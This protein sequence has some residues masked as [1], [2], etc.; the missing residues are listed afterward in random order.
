MIYKG[1]S[2]YKNID[3]S[4]L[5]EI[6][7]SSWVDISDQ[8]EAMPGVTVISKSFFIN[9]IIGLY[10]FGFKAYADTSESTVIE[11][12]KINYT[13]F[14]RSSG[15]A[16]ALGPND[17]QLNTPIPFGVYDDDFIGHEH[18]VVLWPSL[19]NMAAGATGISG[20][21]ILK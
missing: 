7:K 3:W 10:R 13:G 1:P 18:R 11:L 17:T 5:G 9:E 21:G 14:V 12:V 6:A 19:S 20:F 16:M 8:L 2:V 4:E 15:I